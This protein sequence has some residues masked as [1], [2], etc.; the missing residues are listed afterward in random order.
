MDFLLPLV[1]SGQGIEPCEV[2]DRQHFLQGN[3]PCEVWDR[4]RVWVCW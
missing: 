4:Q 2:R 3:E 1:R